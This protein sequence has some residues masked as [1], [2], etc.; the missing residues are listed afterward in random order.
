M[1]AVCNALRPLPQVLAGWE[2]GSAAFDL[3]DEYSDIDLNFLLEDAA[4]VDPAHA[5]V[6]SALSTI[7]RSGLP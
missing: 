1:G 6:E 4:P 7:S 3:V 2:G 5:V